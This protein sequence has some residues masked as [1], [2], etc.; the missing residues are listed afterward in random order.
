V[1]DGPVQV[2]SHARIRGLYYIAL[3]GAGCEDIVEAALRGG[4]S[5]VQLRAKGVAAR[6]FYEAALR[7][8]E[9]VREAG[10]L[11]IVNDSVEVALAAGADGVHVGQD[12]MPPGAIRKVVG[13][14]MLVGV[15]AHSVEEAVRAEE[16]GADYV[17]F[18]PIFQTST[19]EDADAVKGPDAI[20]AVK[21]S[22]S[23]PVVAIGGID[24]VNIAEV[25]KSG[26]DAAA[27]ASAVADAD[28]PEKAAS[29]I[30]EAFR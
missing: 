21:A 10:A 20:L 22:V 14:D 19:K 28:D 11:F 9:S 30:S 29:A 2:V 23:I 3:P 8:R 5:V 1:T 25:V 6:Q 18:G 13:R 27:V 24:T 15:S 16:S 17:G 4:A 26:A 7:L 12:D